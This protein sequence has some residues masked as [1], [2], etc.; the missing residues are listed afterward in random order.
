MQIIAILFPIVALVAL[1]VLAGRAKLLDQAAFRVLGRFVM[2][3]ALPATIFNAISS[4]PFAEILDPDY[5]IVYAIGSLIA[6]SSAYVL[7]LGK[8]A[9][10]RALLALGASAA[11]TGFIGYPV[12]LQVLGPVAGVAAGLTMLVENMLVIPLALFLAA[13]AANAHTPAALRDAF[14]R[15]AKMPLIW[16]VIAG[17][18][19]SAVGVAL[20]ELVR[21]PISLL[22][23]A[24]APVA[25]I[26]VGGVLSSLDLRALPAEPLLQ[27]AIKLLVHPLAVFA[28]LQLFPNSLPTLQSAALIF[29]AAPVVTI[30]PLLGAPFGMEH[31]NAVYLM[32]STL[33]A[34]FTL[35]ILL[36][37][38]K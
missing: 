20:P 11:N 36:Y 37:L 35:P 16:A 22:A 28:A 34:A 3:F 5:L 6:F 23:S 4:H 7:F 13:R 12:A 32:L 2:L 17:F 24:S 19:L 10:E 9:S 27:T 30:F 31:R 21:R 38:V 18:A 26:F 33:L 25:L 1:G 29:A 14:L 8:P 15:V